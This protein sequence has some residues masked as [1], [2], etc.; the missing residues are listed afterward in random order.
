[1]KVT[2]KELNKAFETFYFALNNPK[3]TKSLKLNQWNE[4]KLLP[5]VR[6]F[7]L[8]WFGDVVPEDIASLPGGLTGKGRIDFVVGNV[9][10]ELAV[11]KLGGERS[12][13]SRSVNSNEAKK[14]MKHNGLALLVLL[15][16]TNDPLDNDA[17]EKFRDWPSLGQG[18]HTKSSFNLSYFYKDN[19]TGLL[20]FTVK[21]IRV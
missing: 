11:R 18:N 16:F 12:Y 19:E 14:L 6:T 2:V 21:N 13:L 9:A 4:R 20:T 5:L 10:V 3:F 15:D 17:L 7:L 1:M 8:G